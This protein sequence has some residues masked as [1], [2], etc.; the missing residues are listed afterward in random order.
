MFQINN[1]YYGNFI[2]K[3]ALILIAVIVL[4]EFISKPAS[5]SPSVAVLFK[6][7]SVPIGAN[8]ELS[9]SLINQD[10]TPVN[11]VTF[12]ST[13]QIGM[14]NDSPS[15]VTSINCGAQAVA[16]DGGN[17]LSLIGGTIPA[18]GECLISLKIKTK[19]GI[20]NYTTGNI[21]TAAGGNIPPAS[22]TLTTFLAS[23]T[24]D[25][26]FM[27]QSVKVK[28]TSILKITFTNPNPTKDIT[29]L[30]FTD[31]Y[32]DGLVNDATPNEETKCGGALIANKN[33]NYI[34]LTNGTI[35]AGQSCYVKV[36]V[37]S[38]TPNSY[39]NNSGTVT[40]SNAGS[41]V[42][43]NA[44]LNTT[45]E[46]TASIVFSPKSIQVAPNKTAL[47]T[48]N[49]TNKNTIAV[50]DKFTI[51][52]P[53]NLVNASPT[54]VMTTCGG[55]VEA[56]LG[57]N[58]VTL[59][60]GMIPASQSCFISVYVTSNT[61]GSYTIN[62][63]MVTA[64]TG[65]I[66]LADSE[67]L[68]L[69]TL[70]AP[71]VNV[72]FS[73]S[74]T[75]INTKSLLTI[76]LSNPNPIDI[77]GVSI[78]TSYQ[79][80]LVN[81]LPIAKTTCNAGSVSAL[82]NGHTLTLSN[83]TIPSGQSCTISVYVTSAKEYDY[84]FETGSITTANAGTVT[85]TSAILSIASAPS[86][87]NPKKN[88]GEGD[89]RFLNV[90]IPGFKSLQSAEDCKA[91]AGSKLTITSVS[92]DSAI[93]FVRFDKTKSDP[94]SPESQKNLSKQHSQEFCAIK[95]QYQIS[96]D[97]FNRYDT[98]GTGF[99]TGLLL[100]PYKL[101]LND[102]SFSG[103]SSVGPYIG[104]RTDWSGFSD[105][106]VITAWLGV[107]SSANG[108]DAASNNNATFSAAIGQVF[109]IVKT[110]FQAGLLIGVDWSGN[111]QDKYDGKPWVA[112]SFG[113]NFMQ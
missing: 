63:G 67:T 100:T 90:E 77:Y 66:I 98:S 52:Y 68:T 32:P 97:T 26:S 43:V 41:I 110:N 36:N 74:K 22:A 34:S 46:P 69:T 18:N 14:A 30:T 35:P 53:P 108:T 113:Y 94:P 42:S 6:P 55:N 111:K 11:G 56:G 10:S 29:G 13:Y 81:T 70:A 9:I 73:P 89:S 99:D 5:A 105:V 80:G 57:G 58:S 83:G 48:V 78:N 44:T 84:K 93:L 76:E 45:V 91:Q 101:H 40:T 33:G 1:G 2:N 103:S 19:E 60:N 64:S 24:V 39:V 3:S 72:T 20:Y 16:V 65:S 109:S 85:N 95:V 25:M 17:T 49:I 107:T 86:I 38:T 92:A 7:S 112:L 62:P 8:T 4:L 87:K 28:T 79:A 82:N 37:T 59:S 21:S 47:M 15:K 51:T 54:T 31:N 61:A 27:P 23:P 12:N 71:T 88:L 106:I 102:H 104:Y 75:F 96:S 50:T